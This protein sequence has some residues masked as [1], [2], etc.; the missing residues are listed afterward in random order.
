MQLQ[1]ITVITARLANRIPLARDQVVGAAL[2][3]LL[4]LGDNAIPHESKAQSQP[5]PAELEK[6][7]VD[8]SNQ[9]P[10]KAF[11]ALQRFVGAGNVAVQYLG[12]QIR[13]IPLIKQERIRQWI[14]DIESQDQDTRAVA[15][16][17]LE[18]LGG[19]AE[20]HLRGALQASSHPNSRKTIAHLLERIE[21]RRQSPE[22]MRDLR[23]VEV[24]ETIGTGNAR[25]LL[26]RLGAGEPLAPLT[27]AA[28]SALQRLRGRE[29]REEKGTR[30]VFDIR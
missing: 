14:H 23:I 20:T 16:R 4:F 22:E 1:F 21:K 13:P 26:K 30:I 15:A 27:K 9:D 5:T 6:W 28:N 17:E 29:K 11:R 12:K 10:A 2:M 25:G 8:L 7:W 3:V 18:N 19:I 24:M